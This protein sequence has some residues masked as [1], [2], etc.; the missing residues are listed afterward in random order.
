CLKT[1][2]MTYGKKMVVHARDEKL[3]I[4]FSQDGLVDMAPNRGTHR[5][6]SCIRSGE[7]LVDAF[8]RQYKYNLDVAP[9]RLQL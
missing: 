1:H 4:H 3:L 6:S 5:E 2:L 7:D 9:D 8:L